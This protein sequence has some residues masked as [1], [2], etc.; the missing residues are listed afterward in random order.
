MSPAAFEAAFDVPRGT[1]DRLTRY[2]ALLQDWQ[3]RMNL[4]APST[5]GDIWGRHFADSAQLARLAPPGLDW[6]DFGA[7]AGFPGLVL[8]AME[9]GRVELVESVAKKCR[10][11][12]AVADALGLADR[13][14]VTCARV[15]AL[16][17]RHAPVITARATAP[18]ARLLDWSL[19]H[20]RGD[21]RWIFPKGRSW[22]AEVAAAR[23]Q[24]RFDCEVV[25][26]L[27]DPAARVLLVTNPKRARG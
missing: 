10:F 1:I 4:V 18:L 8:A 22:A 3:T 26:S 16:P 21:T 23:H 19:R 6:L 17:P 11:L 12:V 2:A 9:V 25:E 13:V 7:G 27:T 15:E 24:F 5:L 20:G 14:R